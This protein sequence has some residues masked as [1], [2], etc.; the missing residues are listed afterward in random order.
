MTEA[1]RIDLAKWR[2]RRLLE[3]SARK[4]RNKKKY[5]RKEKYKNQ[6]KD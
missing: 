6:Q 3:A 5:F 2:M 4:P 1:E